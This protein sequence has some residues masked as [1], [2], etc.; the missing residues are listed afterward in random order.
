MPHDNEN[1]AGEVGWEDVDLYRFFARLLGF[2]SRDRFDLL[3]RISSTEVVACLWERLN[4]KA[5]P[6][7]TVMFQSFEQYESSY[8][9]L[10]EVGSPGPP[11][12]LVE[13][14]YHETIPVQQTVLENA[15]F[16][17]VIQLKADTSVTSPDHLLAQ[18]E[19]GASVRYLHEHCESEMQRQDL[20][21]L[22]RDFLNQHML[23]WLPI[24]LAKLESLRPP[25]LPVVFA[26][27]VQFL[28]SRLK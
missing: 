19:F 2:P 26:L 6:P 24:A 22:E 5:P 13:S 10:F 25:F 21:R 12:P 14:F 27:L 23:S 7:P 4:C 3:K 15:C 16:H 9:A 18:L 20:R 28:R 17:D 1:G 11:V 8:I